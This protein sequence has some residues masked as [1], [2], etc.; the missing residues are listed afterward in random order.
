MFYYLQ[1]IL[2]GLAYLAPIGMQ[3]LFLINS[4]I[5][6]PF[7]K[8]MLSS[9]I[10][11]FFD[12]LLA[13]TCF[14]GIGKLMQEYTWLEPII[15][16][17]G[18]VVIIYIGIMLLRSKAMDLEQQEITFSLRRIITTAAVCTWVNPQAI[19]DG[20]ML[21]GAF[22]VSLPQEAGL[23]FLGGVIT[24]SFI[25]FYGVTILISL[26]KSRINGAILQW[27]NRICAIVIIFYGLKLLVEFFL[28][29]I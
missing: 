9:S 19:I 11:I 7:G 20:T 13:I 25:W 16:S 18:S 1:G 22:Q 23:I 26:F 3:N 15:I 17:V 2:I 4:S 21:L 28:Y 24:A 8:A 27:I 10:L 5:S 14:F 29:H 12:I 6:L